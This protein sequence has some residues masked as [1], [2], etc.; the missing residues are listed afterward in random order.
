MSLW[1]LDTDHVSLFQQG[2]PLVMQRV[3][4]VNPTEIALTV[5]TV[6]EQLRGRLNRLRRADSGN[7]MISAYA[8]LRAT[9][10][11]F[12]SVR[13]EESARLESGSRSNPTPEGV[14]LE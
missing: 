4:A 6:E 8:R 13:R 9:L 14:G 12:S 1:V 2:H 3:N 5:I 7:E 11:Y 10:D